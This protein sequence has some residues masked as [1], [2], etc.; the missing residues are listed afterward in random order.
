MDSTGNGS[1]P[2]GASL[3][4]RIAARIGGMSRAERRVAEYLRDNAEHVIFATAEQIGAASD[5]SDATVVRTAKTLGYS[6]LLELKYSLGQQ[7][8]NA[9]KPSIRLRNR[10]MQAGTETQSMLAHVFGEASERLAETRRLLDPAEFERTVDAFANAREILAIGYGPSEWVARYLVLRLNRLGRRA[11]ATGMTGFRLADDL[12]PLTSDDLVAIFLP[13]RHLREI[14]TVLA[15]TS[16]L[17]A[18]SVLFSYLLRQEFGDRVDIVLPAI[19]S[20]SGFS[21]ETLS[22]QV[23]TDAI[24]LGVAA[25]DRDRATNSSELLNQLRRPLMN[26]PDA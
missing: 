23:L 15:H 6:G 14:D 5:T 22:S 9:T 25:R 21:G 16:G 3:R 1:A 18:R 10:I 7:V 13:G 24:L 11:R 17:G 4:E 20:A 8:L 19:H 26:N 12:M 2:A